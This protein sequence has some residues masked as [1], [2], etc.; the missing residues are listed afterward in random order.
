[1]DDHE[2]GQQSGG[3]QR[4]GRRLALSL[5]LVLGVAPVALSLLLTL[6]TAYGYGG[7]LGNGG[8]EDGTSG[9]HN[10][11][12]STFVTVTSPVWSGNWAASLTRSDTAG[13]IDI[14]QDVRVFAGSSYTL[15]GWIYEDEPAISRVCLRIEWHDSQWPPQEDCL[16]GD[17]GYYRPITIAA[18]TAPPDASTARIMVVAELLDADPPNPAYFDE[19]SL[20]S[21]M[22][23]VAYVPLLLRDYAP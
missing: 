10:S 23:P 7:L 12:A 13:E 21:N 6:K 1:M 2:G 19:I 8:F 14:H 3:G 5:A 11:Y 9:W 16:S 17:V 20:T 15:T 18:V 22:M 4:P